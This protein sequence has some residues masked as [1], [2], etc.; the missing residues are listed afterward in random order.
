MFKKWLVINSILIILYLFFTLS[1]VYPQLFRYFAGYFYYG[2]DGWPPPGGTAGYIKTIDKFVYPNSFY[3][4]WIS[5]VLSYKDNYWIEI[6]YYKGYE[7]DN[8]LTFFLERSDSTTG[9]VP[10]TTFYYDVRP[11]PGKYYFYY[12]SKDIYTGTWTAGIYGIVEWR[13]TP[14]PNIARDYTAFS[15]TTTPEINIDRTHFKY[16]E[17]KM[18]NGDWRY[19]DT[20]DKHEDDPYGV[21]EISD[22]EFE[23]GGG[24]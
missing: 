13:F 17:Y 20:H 24:G 1:Y 19:W 4:Q 14:N 15:E 22:Y 11:N 21:Y 9:G 6:G 7:T 3:C 18:S 12:I 10:V 8:E 2:E 23:A 5:V 16:L